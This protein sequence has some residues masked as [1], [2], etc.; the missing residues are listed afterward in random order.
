[1]SDST[2]DLLVRGVAAAKA[3]DKD[4]ARFYLKWLLRRGEATPT[5]EADA[6]WWLSE[7]SDDP[8]E[9]RECL[10]RALEIEPGSARVLRS[11]AILDGRLDPQDVVQDHRTI[12]PIK[13]LPTPASLKVR[14]Y[15]CPKC[16]ARAAFDP[17]QR[18]LACQ[19]CGYQS[20]QRQ[21]VVGETLEQ[22]FIATLPTAKAHLWNLAVSRVLKC[23]GC[24][25]VFTL[26]PSQVA[27]ECPFCQSPH[28]IETTESREL[29]EP[30]GVLPFQLDA[31]VATQ[32]VRQWMKKLRF[33][34]G[35][36]LK[37]AALVPPRG[38]Y[39]PYWTFD[40]GGQIAIYQTISIE[41]T[42]TRYK[43]KTMLP[44]SSPPAPSST[45]GVFCNDL[46]VPATRSLPGLLDKLT[47]FATTALLPYSPD[48]LADW[49][50]EIYQVSMADASLVARQR[51]L[52]DTKKRQP[53]H[54]D[55]LGYRTDSSGI[56]INAYKLVLLPVWVTGHRYERKL[57]PALVNGQTGSVVGDAPRSALQQ[58][59]AEGF[60]EA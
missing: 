60:G 14:R 24:G 6:W 50:A 55:W 27:G 40:V 28:V 37:K 21:A 47:D 23:Q 46:L 53:A 56:V 41:Q 3:N 15:T 59:I 45:A 30:D 29:A 5:Q 25:A 43:A 26:P 4:E 34:P 49:P 51:A 32:H 7:V 42:P 2:R 54:S 38:V 9:K 8:A 48:V 44:P 1:M 31:E 52:E 33:R 22:D 13:P 19:F 12:R 57:Y 18:V 35:D 58:W 36:L 16:G 20:G 39:M 17:E 11:R 10:K